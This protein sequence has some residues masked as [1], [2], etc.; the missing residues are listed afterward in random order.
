MEMM[1]NI[2]GINPT[3]LA[4]WSGT[5]VFVHIP[6]PTTGETVRVRFELLPPAG[7]FMEHLR[8]EF[9]KI[10]S[11]FSGK[12]LE[13]MQYLLATSKGQASGRKLWEDVWEKSAPTFGAIRQAV[14]RLNIVLTEHNFGYVVQGSRK[15]IYRFVPIKK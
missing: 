1:N 11:H 14:R 3:N 9:A 13:V 15:G 6:I 10:G 7:S 5:E 4:S 8:R 12:P 2:T